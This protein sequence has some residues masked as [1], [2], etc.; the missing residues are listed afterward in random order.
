MITDTIKRLIKNGICTE[1][2]TEIANKYGIEIKYPGII[3][4]C[5]RETAFSFTT[6]NPIENFAWVIYGTV[7]GM[8]CDYYLFDVHKNTGYQISKC[9]IFKNFL[10]K[11]E[12]RGNLIRLDKRQFR[13]MLKGRKYENI[14]YWNF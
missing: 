4:A 2:V 14:Y 13:T 10:T 8:E 11:K 12:V 1:Y 7:V 5:D 3:I 6:N 9:F